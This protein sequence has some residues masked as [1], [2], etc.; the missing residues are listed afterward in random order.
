MSVWARH[1]ALPNLVSP[2]HPVVM[3][4]GNRCHWGSSEWVHG[5]CDRQEL[6]EDRKL[7]GWI[8]PA[9]SA[10]SAVFCVQPIR[11]LTLVSVDTCAGLAVKERR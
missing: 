8:F 10:H 11:F 6:P 9:A 5:L 3:Q 1:S 4:G 2:K 7:R